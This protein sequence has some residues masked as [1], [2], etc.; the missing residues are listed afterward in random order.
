MGLKDDMDT[1]QM[2]IDAGLSEEYMAGTITD[3]Q[4]RQVMRGNVPIDRSA[5]M[6]QDYR[7]ICERGD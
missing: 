2:Y 7:W 6:R 1:W 5:S 3:E 4:R